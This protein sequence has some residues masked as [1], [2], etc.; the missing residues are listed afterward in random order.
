[1]SKRAIR[2][3]FVIPVLALAAHAQSA[4]TVDDM[5]RAV[6]KKLLKIWKDIGTAGERTVLF[7]S[8]QAGRSSSPGSYPFK[9]TVNIFDHETGYPPNH[10]YGKTCVGTLTDEVF[11]LRMDDFGA[12][13][14]Q[15][16]M[17]P[18]LS[19]K[20][21][22]N[23]T[24]TAIPAIPA[25]LGAKAPAAG[26]ASAQPAAA[27]R[28]AA[29][30]GQGVAVGDYQCW[31]NGQARMLLNFSVLSANQYRDSEGKTGAFTI[32]PSNGRMAFKGGSLDGFLPAGFYAMYHTPQGRPTVSFRNSG[33][34]EVTFCQH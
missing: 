29:T 18:N 20:Q 24:S 4:P 8:V 15:G 13:D 14:A 6:E 28:P 32:D 26:A 16:R 30:P 31:A 25:E 11:V 22:T 23:N 3:L 19:D 17:T 21:C 7:Q 27:M 12:W 9:A 10:Y 2:V 1:M 34:S 33:G 5:K